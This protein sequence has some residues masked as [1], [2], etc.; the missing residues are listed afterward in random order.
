MKTPQQEINDTFDGYVKAAFPTVV[1]DSPQHLDLFRTFIAGAF[2]MVEILSRPH[3]S[4]E[5]A[6]AHVAGIMKIVQGLMAAVDDRRSPSGDR[7]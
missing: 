3:E 6:E 7:N 5:Q 2:T 1:K 4:V